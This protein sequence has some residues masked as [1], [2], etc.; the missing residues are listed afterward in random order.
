M[1][2]GA[3]LGVARILF[4]LPLWVLL[5]GGY[6]IALGLTIISREEIVNLAWDSAGVTT[7]PVTV[8]LLL[9]LGI[10]LGHVVEAVDGFG[11]L[12]L[13]SVGPIVSVLSTG[14][15]IDFQTRQRLKQ[16]QP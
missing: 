12:A 13:C 15:W 6:T 7:G 2:C 5:M 8:P 9:A 16:R 1:G 14:V 3:A 10:G 11:I 4:D